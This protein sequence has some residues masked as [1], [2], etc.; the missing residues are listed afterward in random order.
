MRLHPVDLLGCPVRVAIWSSLGRIG[1]YSTGVGKHILRM[2]IG[3]A[4]LPNVDTSLVFSS[5]LWL[6][7]SVRAHQSEMDVLKAIRLPLP[8]RALE[9]LW[10]TIQAPSV[11]RW[12]DSADWLYCPKELYVPVRNTRLAVTVH[13]LYRFEPA[14]QKFSGYST[15]PFR[16]A[17]R[18]AVQEANLVLAVSEF[19]KTR[20]IELL[21]VPANK[22]RVVGNGV[23]D[24]FF[25]LTPPPLGVQSL[26]A[27]PYVLAVGGIT[28][29][30][31][32]NALL[33]VVD[34]L[35][36]IAPE[37]RV[38]VTGPVD[39]EF[40][41]AVTSAKNL[42]SIPRGF[43]DAKMQEL[44]ASASVSLV[45]SEYEGFGI[46]AIEAMAAGVPV[47][48][49]QRASLPEVVGDGG[50]LVNPLNSVAVA[51]TIADLQKD[52]THRSALIARGR[53]RAE[54]FRWQGCVSRLCNALSDFT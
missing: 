20:L 13:D 39:A 16:I 50:L 24:A 14:Y 32:G 3:L 4:E 36:R 15:L 45:L 42:I 38:V 47:I 12:L 35:H 44:V 22:I 11:D 53:Q 33:A 6:A 29:K 21:G 43:P 31:G 41:S 19:T 52:S 34:Q 51:D 17:V 5:D 1:H 54:R 10:R 30:K 26:F 23:D 46:P 27:F 18:K 40:S 48:A 25:D 28:H 8:R 37:L 2:S 9:A 7:D 49:A